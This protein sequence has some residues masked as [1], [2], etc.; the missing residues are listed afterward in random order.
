MDQRNFFWI[1]KT[2][3][4]SKKCFF[5]SKKLFSRCSGLEI[6]PSQNTR[7]KKWSIVTYIVYLKFNIS[8]QKILNM[9]RFSLN[10]NVVKKKLKI[11]ASPCKTKREMNCVQWEFT[12]E[13]GRF[14]PFKLRVPVCS[15]R[16]WISS[17]KRKC[18][19]E[20]LI[21]K[22][23]VTSR[24]VNSHQEYYK[25]YLSYGN[26]SWIKCCINSSAGEEHK[27][28]RKACNK[29][30]PAPSEG[31]RQIFYSLFSNLMRIIIWSN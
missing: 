27:T 29:D 19:S 20:N 11:R 15:Y 8:L 2:F 21:H 28:K 3:F 12:R 23:V 14:F 17:A 9:T 13:A 26:K 24:E 25:I 7:F 6:F 22:V 5:D 4:N 18:H 10:W 31:P 16:L 1:N 30:I